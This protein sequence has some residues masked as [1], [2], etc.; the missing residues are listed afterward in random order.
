MG[1]GRTPGMN[2]YGMG[3]PFNRP[4]AEAFFGTKGTLIT[5]RIGYEVYPEVEP[6]TTGRREPAAGGPPRRQRASRR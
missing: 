4:H 2:Y 6:G 1:G 5:D 3:G